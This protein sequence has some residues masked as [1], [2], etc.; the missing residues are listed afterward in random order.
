[1]MR[2][3]LSSEPSEST[4]PAAASEALLH[5]V[6]VDPRHGRYEGGLDAGERTALADMGVRLVERDL[7]H[8]NDPQRHVPELTAKALLELVPGSSVSL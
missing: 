7:V 5:A 6:L 1:M 2:L 4:A 8:E 3:R